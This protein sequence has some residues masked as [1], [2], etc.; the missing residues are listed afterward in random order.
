M[1]SRFNIDELE[2]NP[3]TNEFGSVEFNDID[4]IITKDRQYFCATR[5]IKKLKTHLESNKKGGG[6]LGLTKINQ[7]REHYP[8]LFLPYVQGLG[9]GKVKGLYASFELLEPIVYAAEPIKGFAWL[10]NEPW[11]D[12]DIH[13]YLYLLQPPRM[14]GSNVYKIGETKNI[15]NRLNN[16]DY[17]KGTMVLGI[18][19]VNDRSKAE[20]LMKQWFSG[21]GAL[22]VQGNEYFEVAS[23]DDAYDLFAEA[24]LMNTNEDVARLFTPGE[25]IH[26]ETYPD[27]LEL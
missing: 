23:V 3:I 25:W 18:V 14:I 13:G 26:G 5:L 21:H 17:G 11:R 8:Y 15:N 27:G 9:N 16:N 19:P 12:K 2:Y 22:L 6:S 24:N 7:F 20:G 4:V 10:R 1:S